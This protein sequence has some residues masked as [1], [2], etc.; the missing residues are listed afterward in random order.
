M[1]SNNHPGAYGYQPRSMA[2][3][4]YYQPNQPKPPVQEDTLAAGLIDIERKTFSIAL[5]DNPRG[6]F[7]RITEK[8]GTRHATIIIPTTG[9]KEFQQVLAEMVQADIDLPQKNPPPPSAV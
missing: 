8:N 9:L 1:N 5:K 3:S 2:P 7:L 6:R 4:P